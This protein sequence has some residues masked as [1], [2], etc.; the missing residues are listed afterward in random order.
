MTI[1][2]SGDMLTLITCQEVTE[3][4]LLT[5]QGYNRECMSEN[6]TLVMGSADSFPICNTNNIFTH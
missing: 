2:V 4:I 3:N 6:H 5:M 1:S